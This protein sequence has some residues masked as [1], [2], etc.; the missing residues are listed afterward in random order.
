MLDCLLELTRTFPRRGEVWV[1]QFSLDED[2]RGVVR[3]KATQK[4]SMLAYLQ[5]M[6]QSAVLKETELRD[7]NESGR[8]QRVV[9]FEITFRYDGP[10]GNHPPLAAES[11]VVDEA[12]RLGRGAAG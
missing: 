11:R 8:E 1:T 2:R 9:A 12:P 5:A 3:G 6:Q 10:A 7:W 4:E